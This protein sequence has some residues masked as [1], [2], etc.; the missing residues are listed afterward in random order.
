MPAA[1]ATNLKDK[2]WFGKQDPYCLLTVG[3]Q[4]LRSRTATDGGK[5]P[6]WNQTFKFNVINENDL[7]ITCKDEDVSADDVIG[8]GRAQLARARTAGTDRQSVP[9]MSRNGKQHGHVQITLTFVRNSALAG[10]APHGAVP[11]YGGY[12]APPQYQAYGMPPPYQAPYGAPPPYGYPPQPYGAPPPGAYP[13]QPYGAPP[14]GAYPPQ[15]Y[16]APPPGAY[17]PQGYGAPPPGAY[18]PQAHAAPPPGAY[19]PQGAPG[20]YPPQGYGAPPPH[21]YPPNKGV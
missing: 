11:G 12:A 18:P 17:P 2:D 6:V 5:N 8:T 4:T 15:G 9:M 3:G 10:G 21:G 19:P 1:N 20:A 16:G 14:P 7:T 13:P